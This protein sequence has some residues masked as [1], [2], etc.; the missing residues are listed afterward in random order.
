MLLKERM[1][2]RGDTAQIQLAEQT[3]QRLDEVDAKL[4]RAKLAKREFRFCTCRLV[5]SLLD[6]YQQ[7]T[8]LY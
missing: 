3:L 5:G 2:L 8:S 7:A 4:V 1:R 6:T